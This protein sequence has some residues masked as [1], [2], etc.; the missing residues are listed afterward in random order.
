MSQG[1]PFSR[2]TLAS[3]NRRAILALLA[4]GATAPRVSAAHAAAGSAPSDLP[5]YSIHDARVAPNGRTATVA[6][7]RGGPTA[8]SCC[9]R[10]EIDGG[11]SPRSGAFV[12]EHDVD[13]VLVPVL[14][15]SPSASAGIRIRPFV[16]YDFRPVIAKGEARIGPDTSDPSPL[17]LGAIVR[18][19]NAPKPRPVAKGWMRDFYSDLVKEFDCTAT[20]F[21]R[22]GRP[23]FTNSLPSGRAQFTNLEVGLY[24]DPGLHG[25][26]P[27]QMLNGRRL[28][29]PERLPRPTV[30]AQGG[31]TKLCTHSTPLVS[32][33]HNGRLGYGRFAYRFA[34][35][36]MQ[37]GCWPAGWQLCLPHYRWP[38]CE[39]DTVEISFNQPDPASV[40]PY[41]TNWWGAAGTGGSKEGQFVDIERLLPNFRY[42]EPHTYWSEWTPEYM[43]FGIDEILTFSVPNR[44]FLANPADP[45]DP[46]RVFMMLQIALGGAGGNAEKGFYPMAPSAWAPGAPAMLVEHMAHYAMPV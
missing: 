24:S 2:S 25:T 38:N 21:D 45:K 35:L 10:F 6:I 20:G 18:A 41:Q 22:D 33:E 13:E 26:A 5:S 46:N 4:A 29:V 15:P 27:L 30:V 31:H 17:A 16:T 32:T 44:F 9:I 34:L 11:A 37:Q 19:W 3:P 36:N 42:D 7:R 43:A 12:F 1:Q 40:L 8:Y 28:L 39:Q 23:C 14:L